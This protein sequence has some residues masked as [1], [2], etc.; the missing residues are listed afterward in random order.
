MPKFI[1]KNIPNALELGDNATE[2]SASKHAGTSLVRITYAQAVLLPAVEVRK[3]LDTTDSGSRG[4]Y[5][6]RWYRWFAPRAV[7]LACSSS[8]ASMLR[9]AVRCM[10]PD[11]TCGSIGRACLR[12]VAHPNNIANAA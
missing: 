1:G 9:R 11:C 7:I 10:R 8:T 3:S 5:A 2:A 12:D 4:T 6:K